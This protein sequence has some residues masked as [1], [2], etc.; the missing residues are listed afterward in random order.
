M[1][2]AA[3]LAFIR[4]HGIVLEAARGPVPNLAETVAGER[5]QGSWWGHSKGHEIFRLTR[6]IR[7]SRD[8]LVCRLVRH[9][10]SYVHRRLWPA[11]VRLAGDFAPEDLAALY[12]IH[13]ARGY[14]ELRVVPFPRWVPA[15][16]TRRARRLTEAQARAALPNFGKT[17]HRKG[18]RS[19]TKQ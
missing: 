3:G 17:D 14:H 12:E 18:R 2:A 11:L 4:R 6:T 19:L 13:T 15:A 7:S 16:V 10:I 5:I 9:R 8:V 1:N